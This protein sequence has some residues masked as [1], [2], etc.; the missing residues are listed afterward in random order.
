MRIRTLWQHDGSDD[1][2]WII[3]AVDEFTEDA[4]NGLPAEYAEKL[5]KDP[6]LRELIIEVP[7]E[8]ITGLFTAKKVKANVV[9]E[10]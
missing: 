5:K 9:K 8:A 10:G 3:D 4:H 7:D 1:A 2:P 6:A